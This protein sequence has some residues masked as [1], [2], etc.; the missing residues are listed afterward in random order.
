MCRLF[1][2]LNEQK[3]LTI[4]KVTLKVILSCLCDILR[5]FRDYFVSNYAGHLMELTFALQYICVFF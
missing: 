4:E 1:G 3:L 5:C 2:I